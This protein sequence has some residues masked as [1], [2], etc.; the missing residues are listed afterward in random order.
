MPIEHGSV[1]NLLR[2]MQSEPG[3]NRDDVL[4]AVTTGFHSIS[5]ALEIYLPLISGARLVIASQE[6]V[7]DGNRLRGLLSENR[8]TFMQATPATWR[9]MLGAGWQ[10]LTSVLKILLWWR[11]VAAGTC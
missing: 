1:V 4:L 7:I 10:E 6:D 5:P 3:L 11:G 2:S 8:V 9:L